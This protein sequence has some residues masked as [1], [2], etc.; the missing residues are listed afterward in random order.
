MDF[1]RIKSRGTG[2]VLCMA[3]ALVALVTA[4]VFLLTQADAAPVGHTGIVPG[5]VLLAGAIVSVVFV[6]VPFRFAALVQ[7]V[8]YGTATYFSIT[9]LY[10]VFADVINK[11]TFAGGNAGLCV[12]YMVGA[13]ASC[14]LCVIACFFEQPVA[15]EDWTASKRM[16]PAA[17]ALVVAAVVLAIATMGFGGSAKSGSAS[18][19][20]SNGAG[21][22]ASSSEVATMTLA[23]NKYANMTIDELAATPYS[24]WVAKEDNGEVA[25][26]F[27]GQYT[28]GFSIIL[29][30]ACLDMYL[31]KDGSMYGS[32]TGPV[33]SVAGGSPTYVYGYW[34]NVDESGE[35]DFVIH[36]TGQ[37]DSYG[38]CSPTPTEAGADA[39]IQ[40][41]D[42]V[43]G[44]YSWEASFSYAYYYG[45]M[46][47]NMNI[48]GQQYSPAQSVTIDASEL[49]TFYTGDDFD[50]S[51]L[52]VTVVRAS[53]T[54][55]TIWAGRLRYEGYDSDTIGTK[56]VTG[57]FL[58]AQATFDVKVD[59]LVT[60]IYQGNYGL[61]VDDAVTDSAAT[62]IVDYSHN[63]VTLMNADGSVVEN[64]TLVASSDT[65][66][67]MSI[68]GSDPLEVPITAAGDAKT[69]TIP[70]HTENVSS[71]YSSA[72]YEVGEAT[73]TLAN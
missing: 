52:S 55:D 5:M 26:F 7:A 33:T 66:Y 45:S 32:L 59:T 40:I 47:R 13:F 23:D 11:V 34:Y 56:T 14:L 30:P 53:G 8:I 18:G 39:D 10:Y 16:F 6:L 48:Y 43:H 28:E 61:V 17:G 72:S 69:I 68:N 60:D 63:T 42:T 19:T 67:T 31:C 38:V 64:G 58:G 62:M 54:T 20:S 46:T 4:I 44:D 41:F 51:A 73:L 25:Y 27:E 65:S 2:A 37:L 3:A 15:E 1:E 50:C 71:F 36:L 9:Q 21:V 49:G 29:D 35:S 24:E 70:A 57:K 22:E 12:A